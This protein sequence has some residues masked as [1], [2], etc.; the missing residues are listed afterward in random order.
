MKRQYKKTKVLI[1]LGP[2]SSSPAMVERL[3]NRG[4]NCFR[5]NFSH[6]TI[7]EHTATIKTIRTGGKKLGIY[8]GILFVAN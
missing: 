2:A 8:P 5:V 7:E 4:A 3:I 6:G 1:T